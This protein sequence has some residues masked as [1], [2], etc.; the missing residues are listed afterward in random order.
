M[1]TSSTVFGFLAPFMTDS[2]RESV[3]LS[4]PLKVAD[5]KAT[6][7]VKGIVPASGSTDDLLAAMASAQSVKIKQSF[8][9]QGDALDEK[10]RAGLSGECKGAGFVKAYCHFNGYTRAAKPGKPG[11]R[12]KNKPATE[13][14]VNRIAETVNGNGK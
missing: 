12:D 9:L 5:G 1:A 13:A 6:G 2:Q 8:P 11:K 10:D 7:T 4:L 14:P 3:R